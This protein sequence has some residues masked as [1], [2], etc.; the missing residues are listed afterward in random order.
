MTKENYLLHNGG[1]IIL[2]YFYLKCFIL[3]FIYL[4]LYPCVCTSCVHVFTSVPC[5]MCGGPLSLYVWGQRMGLRSSG[6]MHIQRVLY[7]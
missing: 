6:L 3:T 5:R 4:F 7:L 1:T 2:E